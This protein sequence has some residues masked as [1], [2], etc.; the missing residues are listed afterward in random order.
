MCFDTNFFNNYIVFLFENQTKKIIQIYY[1]SKFTFYSYQKSFPTIECTESIIEST[2]KTAD[3]RFDL[4]Y[5]SKRI[6]I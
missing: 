6:Y 2:E 1:I 3:D 5:T 4:M